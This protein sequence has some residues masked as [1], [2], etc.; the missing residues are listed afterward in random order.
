M[1]LGTDDPNW[2]AGTP[3]PLCGVCNEQTATEREPGAPVPLMCD[4]CLADAKRGEPQ[5]CRSCGGFRFLSG[6]P[7]P[8]CNGTGRWPPLKHQGCY[9]GHLN[10][11]P[12]CVHAVEEGDTYKCGNPMTVPFS[13]EGD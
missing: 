12:N 2:P 10:D 9:D 5:L 13:W 6:V 11:C 3:K 4:D 7:C 8:S 1:R